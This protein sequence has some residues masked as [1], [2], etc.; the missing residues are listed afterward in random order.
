MPTHATDT[1]RI[2]LAGGRRLVRAGLRALL[3]GRPGWTVAAE[4]DRLD[5]AACVVARERPDFV[6]F[7]S[8]PEGPDGFESLPRVREAAPATCVLVIAGAHEAELHR[9]AALLGARGIVYREC[10]GETLFRALDGV[11]AGEL[12]FKRSLLCRLFA[13]RAA[14]GARRDPEAEKIASLTA[15]ERRVI[16]HLCEGLKN[17]QIADRLFVSNITVRHHLVRVYDKLGVSTRLELTVYAYR[18]GLAQP[19]AQPPPAN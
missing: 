16:A 3:E 13:E 5:E 17:Q 18:H 10:E 9:R 8:D 6:I 19:P 1:V 7:D 12:W 14:E 4:C 15:Q 11:R 2:V